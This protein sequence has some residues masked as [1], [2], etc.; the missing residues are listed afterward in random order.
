M[1]VARLPFHLLALRKAEFSCLSVFCLGGIKPFYTKL[2][3]HSE[4]R[5]REGFCLTRQGRESGKCPTVEL[6]SSEFAKTQEK[7]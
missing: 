1:L 2:V 4:Q 7:V 6:I 5:K 3:V